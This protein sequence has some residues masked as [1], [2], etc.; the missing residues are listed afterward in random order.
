MQEG[1]NSEPDTS[2]FYQGDVELKNAN[3]TFE[4]TPEEQEELLKCASDVSYFG[5]TYCHAMTDDG[6]TK[7]KLRPYQKKMLNAFQDNRYVVM[8]ASRQIGKCFLF[9]TK[10]T[11]KLNNKIE[12]LPIYELWFRTLK[13]LL[14]QYSI[15]NKII[16]RFKYFLFKLYDK[17]D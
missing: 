7:I 3:L 5:D 9:N 15:K 1:S 12:V 10:I 8:M 17:L 2:C 6:V 4:Y 16:L 13:P 14:T 11:L